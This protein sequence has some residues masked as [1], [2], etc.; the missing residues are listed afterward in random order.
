ELG[1]E[2]AWEGE[3]LDEVGRIT[4]CEGCEHLRPGQA[5]VRVDPRYFRP[6]AAETLLG[7]PSKAR[8][9]LGW[10]PT[11]SFEELVREMT[12]A[13]FRSAQRDALVRSHGYSSYTHAE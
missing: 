12:Q 10:V 5:T 11:T 9:K 1:I 8:Q 13:D 3:G 7:D 4:R 6:T 2:L